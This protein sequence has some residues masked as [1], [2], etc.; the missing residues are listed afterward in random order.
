VSGPYRESG[1]VES[2]DAKIAR[3]R[4]EYDRIAISAQTTPNAN[5]RALARMREI[6]AILCAMGRWT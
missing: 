4:A 2:D 5:A 6:S 1:H 3:L